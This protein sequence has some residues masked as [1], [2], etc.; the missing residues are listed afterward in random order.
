MAKKTLHKPS[1]PRRSRSCCRTKEKFCPGSEYISFVI[2]GDEEGSLAREDILLSYWK[3]HPE[4]ELIGRAKSSWKAKIPLF[5]DVPKEPAELLDRAYE[6]FL[7]HHEKHSGDDLLKAFILAMF[8]QRKKVFIYRQEMIQGDQT[9][10]VFE[11]AG[12]EEVYCVPVVK[13]TQEQIKTL[14]DEFSHEIGI[15]S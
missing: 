7:E 4:Q 10:Y 13:P 11:A 2:E 9:L 8:L 14:Q 5:K 3:E 1:I 12:S 15:L 6:L